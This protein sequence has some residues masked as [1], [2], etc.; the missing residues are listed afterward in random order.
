MPNHDLSTPSGR[1]A[2]FNYLLT[3]EAALTPIRAAFPFR[4]KPKKKEKRWGRSK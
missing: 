2:F 1:E 3:E 4:L